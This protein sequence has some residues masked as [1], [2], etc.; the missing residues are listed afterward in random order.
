MYGCKIG[1]N[2]HLTGKDHK[3]EKMYDIKAYSKGTS[4]P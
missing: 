4:E 1:Y 3:E 2:V